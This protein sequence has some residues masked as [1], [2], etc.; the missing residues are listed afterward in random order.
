MTTADATCIPAVQTAMLVFVSNATMVPLAYQRILSAQMTSMFALPCPYY[1]LTLANVNLTAFSRS[2]L[3]AS[4]ANT[5]STTVA[6][7]MTNHIVASTLTVDI[8]AVKSMMAASA[9]TSTLVANMTTALAYGL[10]VSSS[11]LTLGPLTNVTTSWMLTV[12]YNIS[13][14]GANATVTRDLASRAAALGSSSS[15]STALSQLNLPP[16]T[17]N[18][19]P[20]VFVVGTLQLSSLNATLVSAAVSTT[21]FALQMI[22]PGST[23]VSLLSAPLDMMALVQTALASVRAPDAS[24]CLEMHAADSAF[25]ADGEW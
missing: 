23:L 24:L 7:N 19:V 5:T 25:P 10:G 20:S 16:A 2:A 18:S 14:L 1:S 12:A 4:L 11:Q 3:Q 6:A 9:A 21:S 22:Y 13:C 15:L 17:V 8:T